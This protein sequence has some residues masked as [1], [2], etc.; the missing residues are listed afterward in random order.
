[1]EFNKINM[2]VLKHNGWT[3]L[4]HTHRGQFFIQVY[5]DRKVMKWVTKVPTVKYYWWSQLKI[6]MNVS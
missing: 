2:L 1:M 6:L 3:I 4:L 5:L